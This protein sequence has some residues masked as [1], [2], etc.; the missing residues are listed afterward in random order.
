M[1]KLSIGCEQLVIGH[2]V[3]SHMLEAVEAAILLLIVPLNG[4]DLVEAVYSGQSV[5]DVGAQEGVDVVWGKFGNAGSVL[6][7]VGHVAHKPTG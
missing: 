6:G 4:D 7:P 2:H 1:E 5:D 3:N